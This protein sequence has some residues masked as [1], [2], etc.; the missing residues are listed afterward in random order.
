LISP[1][2]GLEIRQFA[3]ALFIDQQPT[4]FAFVPGNAAIAIL[5]SSECCGQTVIK[6]FRLSDGELL[7]TGKAFE[8]PPSLLGYSPNGD[9]FLVVIPGNNEIILSAEDISFSLTGVELI[10]F[11]SDQRGIL[12][13]LN[14]SLVLYGVT[15]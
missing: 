9:L 2:T 1:N 13:M 4:P 5:D 12:G 7:D 11:T 6:H 10:G 8:N 14:D 15:P 3:G